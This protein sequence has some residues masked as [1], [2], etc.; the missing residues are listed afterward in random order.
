MGDWKTVRYDPNAVEPLDPEIV[1]LCDAMWAAGFA[2]ICSCCGHGVDWPRVWFEHSSDA[3]IEYLARFIFKRETGDFRPFFTTVQK[4]ILLDGYQWLLE[5]HLNN[6]YA[7][8]PQ[9]VCLREMIRAISEV[10]ESVS[11]WH[12][13]QINFQLAAKP[14]MQTC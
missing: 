5:I 2:T 12:Q 13:Q 6:V 10:T 9:D 14:R 3:R 7:D 8:T 11:A 1:P 4:E